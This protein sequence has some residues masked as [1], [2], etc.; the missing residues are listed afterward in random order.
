M[1]YLAA[2]NDYIRNLMTTLLAV[3]G[4]KSKRMHRSEVPAV[5]GLSKRMLWFTGMAM[6][7][8]ALEKKEKGKHCRIKLL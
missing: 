1:T 6:I 2:S 3:H 8:Y 7:K 5:S 4:E